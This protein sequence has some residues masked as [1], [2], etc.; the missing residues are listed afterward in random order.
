MLLIS[1]AVL[2]TVNSLRSQSEKLPDTKTVAAAGR[3][4]GSIYKND[5]FR[6]TVQLPESKTYIKVNPS[7]SPDRAILVLGVNNAEGTPNWDPLQRHNFAV[8]AQLR[9]PTNRP[10]TEFVESAR[11]EQE[12]EGFT[13]VRA[14]FPIKIAGRDFIESDL[15][16]DSPNMHYK[17]ILCTTVR[18]YFLGF[19]VEAANEEQLKKLTN[20]GNQVTF[21]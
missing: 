17:A 2:I 9:A 19:W 4:D 7:V 1:L 15:R 5:Y 16:M 10:A 8:I 12:H 11:K 6:L 14:E 18:G 13:T 3:L 20:L 21:R